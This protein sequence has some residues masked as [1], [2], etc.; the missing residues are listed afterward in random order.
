MKRE[1]ANTETPALGVFPLARAEVAEV[2]VA[3]TRVRKEQRAV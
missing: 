1:T 3:A 2:D